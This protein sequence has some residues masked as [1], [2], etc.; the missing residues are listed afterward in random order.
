[1]AQNGEKHLATVFV[2][3]PNVENRVGDFKAL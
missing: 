2:T 3:S 1:L